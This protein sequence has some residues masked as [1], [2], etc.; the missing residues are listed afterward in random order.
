MGHKL[1]P[2][3]IAS[4]HQ[5][6]G[7]KA[8]QLNIAGDGAA[9]ANFFR[10]TRA[11]GHIKYARFTLKHAT[12]S[13]LNGL[14]G[15]GHIIQQRFRW[16]RLKQAAPHGVERARG[17]GHG[18][19]TRFGPANAFLITPIGIHAFGRC[20]IA[21]RITEDQFARHNPNA[22]IGKVGQ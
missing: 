20:H 9:F 10:L 3:R 7:E 8:S 16:N 14:H 13:L 5:P 11:G 12:V 17:T 1:K 18:T 2:D 21:V 19:E 15:N 6:C 22:G 4:R